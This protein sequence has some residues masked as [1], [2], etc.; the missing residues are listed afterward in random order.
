MAARRVNPEW[1]ARAVVLTLAV[2]LPLAGL[3]PDWVDDGHAVRLVAAMPEDGGWLPQDLTATVGEP[4]HLR[5]TSSDVVHG[6][7]IGQRDQPVVDVKPGEVTDL[8]LLFDQPGT[9]TYY[10]TRWCGPNHWRMRGTIEVSGDGEAADAEAAPLYMRLGIDLDADRAAESLPGSM[11]SA[12]RAAAAGVMVPPEYQVREYVLSHS[13]LD[14]WQALRRDSRIAA[15]RDAELWDLV[16]LV[17]RRSTTPEALRTGEE[18][19]GANCAACHGEAGTGDGVMAWYFSDST[20]AR[21]DSAFGVAFGHE[22]VP[23]ADFTDP[24]RMLAASPALLHGKMI[25]GGM[26]T[27]MP[28]WGPIFTDA[29]TWAL[30]DYLWSLQFRYEGREDR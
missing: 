15:A 30:V 2:G 25:R 1:L 6:F 19:Y 3:V 14:V 26:G 7:A 9:Y 11:P 24:R 27:G 17:W 4:L 28:Y 5:L 18:L 21:A 23:P 22:L 20:Q 13:P 29:E 8:T 12:E 16:A 10:C